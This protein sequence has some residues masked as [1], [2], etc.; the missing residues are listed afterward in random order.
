MAVILAWMEYMSRALACASNSMMF[1]VKSL[2]G[3]KPLCELCVDLIKQGRSAPETTA[4]MIFKS[5]FFRLMG[6]VS[7]GYMFYIFSN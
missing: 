2:V 3:V 5:E 6:L 1:V 7:P 4:P